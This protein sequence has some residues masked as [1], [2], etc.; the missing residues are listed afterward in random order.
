[1]KRKVKKE[2]INN[3]VFILCALFLIGLLTISVIILV[4][5]IKLRRENENFQNIL[6]EYTSLKKE[7]D[8]IK[9]FK[10]N[11]NLIEINNQ[12][13]EEEKID[14]ENKIKDLNS[15][16]NMLEEKIEALK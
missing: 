16:I 15:N 6:S 5:N 7:L 10:E 12:K 9:S 3:I 1:M 11:Y 2:K 8:E 14:L 4:N 13:L